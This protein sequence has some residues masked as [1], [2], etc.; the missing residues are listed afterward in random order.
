M[1][2]FLYVLLRTNCQWVQRAGGNAPWLRAER[3]PGLIKNLDLNHQKRPCKSSSMWKDNTN[4]LIGCNHLIALTT[5]IFYF[6]IVHRSPKL[7]CW[8]C[9]LTKQHF[10]LYILKTYEQGLMNKDTIF[11]KT[12]IFPLTRKSR[13]CFSSGQRRRLCRYNE[14]QHGRSA[15]GTSIETIAGVL[16][17]KSLDW[18]VDQK[19]TTSYKSM[20]KRPRG[21]LLIY[22]GLTLWKLLVEKSRASVRTNV[23]EKDCT[24]LLSKENTAEQSCVCLRNIIAT[25]MAEY[26]SSCHAFVDT[27]WTESHSYSREMSINYYVAYNVTKQFS[28]AK[29]CHWDCNRPVWQRKHAANKHTEKLHY[30][31]A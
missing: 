18:R 9:L 1:I 11:L 23:I 6:S 16:T 17:A 24:V 4:L 21:R 28:P 30:L 27:K 7:S 14:L 2:T 31:V 25:I 20:S 26:T 12:T 10:Q 3:M 8:H 5:E 13:I 15:G 29:I 22:W 19:I